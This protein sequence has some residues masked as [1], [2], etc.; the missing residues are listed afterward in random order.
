MHVRLFT[1]GS[2][3]LIATYPRV[4]TRIEAFRCTDV[5]T[6]KQV[7]RCTDSSP[8]TVILNGTACYQYGQRYQACGSLWSCLGAPHPMSVP[9]IAY[10]MRR[11]YATTEKEYLA[12]RVHQPRELSFSLP[13]TTVRSLSTVQLVVDA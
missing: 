2:K 10:H 13:G 5:S 12:R 4:G 11:R 9:G 3:L 6:G 7:S 1:P 8:C